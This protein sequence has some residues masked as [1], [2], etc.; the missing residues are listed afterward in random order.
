MAPDYG[1]VK[2]IHA[3]AAALSIALFLT[4]GAWMLWTP[5]RLRQRWVRI[6]PHVI[7]TVLLA[8]A[9]WL[10]WHA[11]ADGT[12]G[13]LAAKVV[14]LLVY[15]ALGTIALKRGRTRRIRV[16]ALLG[17]VATFAY[18]VSVALTKSPLGVLAR[19]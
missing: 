5:Q 7:D 18:I 8:S 14:A 16:A 12:R 11:G 17:A 1:A 9:L 4:R 10:A 19:W 13:W 6:V 15:I 2:S 3:G